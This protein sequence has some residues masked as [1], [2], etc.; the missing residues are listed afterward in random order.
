MTVLV[1]YCIDYYCSCVIY[2]FECY[3]YI[4]SRSTVAYLY[5]LNA[6]TCSKTALLGFKD[7]KFSDK[8]KFLLALD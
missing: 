5:N 2:C 6:N 7:V 3:S 8:Q 4:K 1:K